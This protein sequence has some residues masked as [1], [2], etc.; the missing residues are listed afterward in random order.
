MH[1]KKVNEM[2]A[3]F[4]NSKNHKDYWDAKQKK[5]KR[6]LNVISP[7]LNCSVHKICGKLL[8][9]KRIIWI[10]GPPGVGKTT[11]VQ[12][13]QNYGCMALDGEDPW[14]RDKRQRLNGL[15]KMSEK[16]NN[17]LK[18]T[19]VFGACYGNYLLEAPEYVIPV[20]IFPDPDVYK[21]RL[22]W[23]DTKGPKKQQLLAKERYRTDEQIAKGDNRVLVLRQKIDECVDVTI[24]RI[25]ELILSKEKQDK[26][27]LEAESD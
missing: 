12:R 2:E 20:L 17:E 11:C 19:F 26:K 8:M 21:K 7:P 25:C 3:V 13:F 23:R 9:K 14:N 24:C 10:G 4:Q 1:P 6:G 22:E 27:A 18:T 15:K 16:A 5:S